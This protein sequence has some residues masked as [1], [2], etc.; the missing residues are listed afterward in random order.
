MGFPFPPVD[1]AVVA[2]EV[3]ALVG[4][5]EART[6]RLLMALNGEELVGW[7]VIRRDTSALVSHWGM[8]QHVQTRTGRRGAGIGSA[9]VKQ[10]H[11]I[12]HE[13]VGLEQLHLAARGGE[14]WRPSTSGSG[15]GRS[16]GGRGRS[17][18]LPGMTGTRS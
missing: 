15:G 8:L 10:A 11:V 4:R 7:L 3:D 16:A 18:L 12:A 9:L 13:E 5:L 17:G 2:A 14:G 1:E 6:C